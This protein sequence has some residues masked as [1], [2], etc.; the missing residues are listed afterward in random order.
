MLLN[1]INVANFITWFVEN[2]PESERILRS[3]PDY[4]YKFK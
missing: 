1:K 2:Y 3:E 4:Q